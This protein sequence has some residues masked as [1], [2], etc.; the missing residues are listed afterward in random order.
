MNSL[1][2][3]PTKRSEGL[4][5]VELTAENVKRIKA[6]SIRPA[7]NLVEISGRNGQG[8]SSV[9]DAIW[10]ALS[11]ATHIQAVPI[12]K[13]A[14]EALIKLDLGTIKVTRTFREKEG[15]PFFA[16]SIVV[17]NE[18]GARFPS[19]QSMLD[20]LVGELSF[21]PLAFARMDAKGQFDALKRFVPGFDFE[22]DKKAYEADFKARTET[23]RKAKDLR[24]Q[25]SG[26]VV[27]KDAPAE[28]VDDAALVADLER[29]GEHNTDLERRKARRDQASSEALQLTE[30]A[31]ACRFNAKALR[32]QADEEDRRAGAHEASAQEIRNK[33]AS[34]E[35]LPAAIDTSAVRR[36]IE[37][38]RAS[39]DLFDRATRSQAER[40]RIEEAASAA[41]R[42]A[43]DLTKA[44]EKR[45][46]DRVATIAAAKMPVEGLSFGDGEI[47]LDGVPFEQGSDAE[48]LRASIAI[49]ME[50][51]PKLRV[52]RVRDG[53]LLDEEAMRLLAEMADDRDYQVWIERVGGNGRV[54]FV[55]EDGS[56]AGAPAG[57]L[58][59]AE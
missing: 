17:E 35:A 52:I 48:R 38:A 59:A 55:I 42:M 7:G 58:A 32:A 31:D 51:N 22:A 4:R 49:A 44:L 8:K 57:S 11:G 46:A 18:D 30:A 19:P 25:A 20:R 36:Q 5:I 14:T 28:R 50:S 40:T 23:A 53:S 24:V 1:F 41:E 47:L 43:A 15:P 33:L 54:G 3:T 29:A 2:D 39:N 9:L 13:G 12:R 27:V 37:A 26:I 16:T 6:V 34:A 21:D 56:T 10:W 45:K